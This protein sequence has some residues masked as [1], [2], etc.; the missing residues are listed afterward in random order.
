MLPKLKTTKPTKKN[1]YILILVAGKLSLLSVKECKQMR[2]WVSSVLF[3]LSPIILW[4]VIFFPEL[5]MSEWCPVAVYILKYTHVLHQK[6]AHTWMSIYSPINSISPSPHKCVTVLQWC[7]GWP[8]MKYLENAFTPT[9]YSHW[10][11]TKGVLAS[12]KSLVPVNTAKCWH[13][14]GDLN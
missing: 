12:N 10:T 4:E 6:I 13:S 5:T 7:K 3:P 11:I 2:M 1:L 9:T 14:H 8:P